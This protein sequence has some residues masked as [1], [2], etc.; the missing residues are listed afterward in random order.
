MPRVR[1][2]KGQVIRADKLKIHITEELKE[3]A[4]LTNTKVKPLIR[5]KLEEEL[6]YQIYASYT[7][8]TEKGKAVSTY[9]KSNTHQQ[10][11][12]YHHTGKLAS[13]V[14]AVIEGNEIKAKLMPGQYDNGK[15]VEEVYNILKFGT[16][17][18]PHKISPKTGKP[19][20]GFYFN[21]K[22]NFSPYIQQQPHNFETETN[23]NMQEFIQKE[24]INKLNKNPKAYAGTKYEKKSNK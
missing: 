10:A 18:T 12:P 7:P 4:E 9:N 21:G 22:S 6:R 14:Y 15:T 19:V 8:A 2:I 5:D 13:K 24:I 1:N 23:R 17:E 3:I 16:S 20:D 11:R